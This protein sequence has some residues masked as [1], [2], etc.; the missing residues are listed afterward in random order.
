MLFTVDQLPRNFFVTKGRG[1]VAGLARSNAANDGAGFV[2]YN[3]PAAALAVFT[4]LLITKIAVASDDEPQGVT[5]YWSDDTTALGALSNVLGVTNH[6]S[7]RFDGALDTDTV[8]AIVEESTLAAALVTNVIGREQT[9]AAA[10][11][12][13]LPFEYPL[14][15]PPGTGLIVRFGDRPATSTSRLNVSWY[16]V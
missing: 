5:V 10:P 13:L 14:I 15:L 7:V 2:F 6:A 12:I 4:Q 1:F 9:Q 16:R 8:A 11:G 3:P